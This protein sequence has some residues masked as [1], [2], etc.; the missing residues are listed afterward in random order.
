MSEAEYQGGVS[1][2]VP[3]VVPPQS[4]YAGGVVEQPQEHVIEQPQEHVLDTNSG[5]LAQSEADKQALQSHVS[6]LTDKV[7][8]LEARL[9]ELESQHHDTRR[10]VSQTKANGLMTR[11]NSLHD[12]ITLLVR[13]IERDNSHIDSVMARGGLAATLALQ[14]LK[15]RSMNIMQNA[16]AAANRVQAHKLSLSGLSTVDATANPVANAAD[17]G[18]MVEPRF[19]S[20]AAKKLTKAR[21]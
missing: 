1:G 10:T 3:E 16:L 18:I 20:A 11:L 2:S 4:E 19:K 21:K 5:I 6:E 12:A 13:N 15:A 17:P 14:Q 8:E 9:N 7:A